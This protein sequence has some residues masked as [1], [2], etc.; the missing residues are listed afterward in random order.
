MANVTHRLT[1]YTWKA[2]APTSIK[3]WMMDHHLT[4]VFVDSAAV[5]WESSADTLSTSFQREKETPTVPVHP[6]PDDEVLLLILD[7]LQRRGQVPDLALDGQHLAVVCDVDDAVDVE[8]DRLVRHGAE[9]VAEAVRIAARV[10]GSEA[11]GARVLSDELKELGLVGVRQVGIDVEVATTSDL[12]GQR[13]L[14]GQLCQLS[15]LFLL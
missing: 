10:L 14:S 6:L 5:E 12:V 4:L 13:H 15:L 7:G 8:A 9:F 3:A 11:V 1:K 2:Q